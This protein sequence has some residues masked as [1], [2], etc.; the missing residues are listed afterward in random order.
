MHKWI[1]WVLEW[2]TA[3]VL[4]TARVYW[5]VPVLLCSVYWPCFYE[6]LFFSLSKP[7]ACLMTGYIGKRFGESVTQ[8]T[9]ALHSRFSRL[10]YNCF[11]KAVVH[12]FLYLQCWT[13]AFKAS[14]RAFKYMY[15]ELCSDQNPKLL[16]GWSGNPTNT[17]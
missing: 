12:Y 2:I 15:F 1:G 7:G 16:L 13:L 5:R 6:G 10:N 14:C 4:Q 3:N 9:M 17:L 11:L 8:V